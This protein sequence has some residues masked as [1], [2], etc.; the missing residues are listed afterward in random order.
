MFYLFVKNGA[1]N[2]S[3]QGLLSSSFVHVD[4]KKTKAS[5]RPSEILF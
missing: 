3:K 5:S 1:E 2:D 4:L